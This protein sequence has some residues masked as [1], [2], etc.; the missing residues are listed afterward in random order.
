MP[1]APSAQ[2]RFFAPG[3]CNTC[4]K[5]GDAEEPDDGA[6]E[7]DACPDCGGRCLVPDEDLTQADCQWF[8][9]RLMRMHAARP[10]KTPKPHQFPGHD[11]AEVEQAQLAAFEAG[12]KRW[13]LTV[14]PG[15]DASRA[16][17]RRG[18]VWEEEDP[19]R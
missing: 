8:G 2:D 10:H 18:W 11:S 12:A 19:Y 17:R 15:E 16:A 13:W 6:D 3:Q 7:E 5:A 9:N 1:E 4:H 14:P